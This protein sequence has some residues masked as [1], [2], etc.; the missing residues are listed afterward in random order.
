MFTKGRRRF[1]INEVAQLEDG[2]LV[3]PQLL[4][5]RNNEGGHE[6]QESLRI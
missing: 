2:S 3:V 6:D 1:W 5:V 4:V